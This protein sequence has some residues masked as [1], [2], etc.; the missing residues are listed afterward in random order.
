MMRDDLLAMI[1]LALGDPEI[2]A[3]EIPSD[4]TFTVRRDIEYLAQ[5]PEIDE[6]GETIESEDL[7]PDYCH[8]DYAAPRGEGWE[9][10]G[11]DEPIE[12]EW[13]GRDQFVRAYRWD[14]SG[15]SIEA[16]GDLIDE[17]LWDAD[18]AEMLGGY[19][20]FDGMHPAIS[21]T[22]DGMDWNQGGWSPVFIATDYLVID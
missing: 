9:R 7:D 1:R 13:C 3:S 22:S 16:M 19:L 12:S 18:S 2:E 11:D 15:I 17:N 21:I 8:P 6:D 4:A 5:E 20:D 10:S 14:R